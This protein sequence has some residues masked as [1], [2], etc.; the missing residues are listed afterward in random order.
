[1]RLRIE[2]GPGVTL[3]LAAGLALAACSERQVYEGLRERER[4]LCAEGPAV[5]YEACLQRLEMDYD[6]YRDHSKG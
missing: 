4:N 6:E 1:M 5:Q 3:M 2:N